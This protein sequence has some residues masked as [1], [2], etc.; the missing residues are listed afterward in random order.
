MIAS[1]LKVHREREQPDHWYW[2]FRCRFEDQKALVAHGGLPLEL[3]PTIWENVMAS[4]TIVV[5]AWLLSSC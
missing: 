4:N 5:G 1:D 2:T 3:G